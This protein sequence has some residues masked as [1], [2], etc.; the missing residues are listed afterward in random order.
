MGHDELVNLSSV[1]S[2]FNFDGNVTEARLN[3][4][5]K[6]N[7]INTPISISHSCRIFKKTLVNEFEHRYHKEIQELRKEKFRS[8]NSFCFCDA[9]CFWAQRKNYLEYKNNKTTKILLQTDDFSSSFVNNSIIGGIYN[10]LSTIFNNTDFLCISDI[11]K[12]TDSNTFIKQYLDNIFINKSKWEKI[13]KYKFNLN[14]NTTFIYFFIIIL[15][16]FY[17]ILI[18]H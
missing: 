13:N 11:R 4:Y 14:I 5:K 1:V 2:V 7:I 15:L 18:Y 8:E 17:I 10:Y 16:L 6:I 12:T 9:F 3:T